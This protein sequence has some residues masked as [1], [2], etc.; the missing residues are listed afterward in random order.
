MRFVT[1][2]GPTLLRAVVRDADDARLERRFGSLRVQRAMFAAMAAGFD[3]RAA[4]GFQGRLVYVLS[5]PETERPPAKWT[6]EVLPGRAIARPGSVED[7]VLTIRYRLAD[8]VRV[9]A[10]LTDPATPM[11]RNRASFDG[12]FG[13]AVRLPEM[14]GAPRPR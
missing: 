6:I 13:L 8:F 3:P 12:D 11:L 7:P 10:G 2:Y 5:R 1:R 9:A 4:D 14:F